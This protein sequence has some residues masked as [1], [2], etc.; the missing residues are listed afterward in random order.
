MKW[1]DMIRY[2]SNAYFGVQSLKWDGTSSMITLI[3]LC[4]TSVRV[5]TLGDVTLRLTMKQNFECQSW[6]ASA[7]F[8]KLIGGSSFS[9]R[10]SRMRKPFWQFKMEKNFPSLEIGKKELCNCLCVEQLEEEEKENCNI[11]ADRFYVKD[12]CKLNFLNYRIRYFSN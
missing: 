8:R 3:M 9:Y 6:L 2:Y 12:N 1:P 11:P 7:V 10:M 5:Q 4:S